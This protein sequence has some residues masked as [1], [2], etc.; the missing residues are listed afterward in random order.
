MND[1]MGSSGENLTKKFL[2]YFD[3]K[4]LYRYQELIKH[5]TVITESN[6]HKKS[7]SPQAYYKVFK[8]YLILRNRIQ[9]LAYLSPRLQTMLDILYGK[10][11]VH[12]SI[13]FKGA[14]SNLNKESIRTYFARV[15]KR[16]EHSLFSI[17]LDGIIITYAKNNNFHPKKIITE[18]EQLHKKKL[19][20]LSQKYK[21]QTRIDLIRSD[22]KKKLRKL[23]KEVDLF[24]IFLNNLY[25]KSSEFKLGVCI[26]ICDGITRLHGKSISEYDSIMKRYQSMYLGV[27]I[28]LNALFI[29]ITYVGSLIPIEVYTHLGKISSPVGLDDL[30]DTLGDIRGKLLKGTQLE[31]QATALQKLVGFFKAKTSAAIISAPPTL[32]LPDMPANSIVEYIKAKL[33][34]RTIRSDIVL[35]ILL[36]RALGS[37]K[38]IV[39]TNN[40]KSAFIQKIEKNQE[41]NITPLSQNDLN[42]IIQHAHEIHRLKKSE[43]KKLLEIKI[44]G[45][46]KSYNKDVGLKS[47]LVVEMSLDTWGVKHI[48]ETARFI[49]PRRIK[50]QI[51]AANLRIITDSGNASATDRAMGYEASTPTD[52][53]Y[54]AA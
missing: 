14:I 20:T 42:A 34:K 17:L 49:N 13:D 23:S 32:D 3:A 15:K 22:V 18:I 10:N 24:Y 4:K 6:L 35:S 2:Q 12:Y 26:E 31:K 47:Y 33:D 29:M 5:L 9:K 54:N 8:E 25:K 45:T 19:T 11:Y 16:K 36:K 39:Y 21:T 50:E 37:P 44:N 38:A 7:I 28:G 46:Q 48:L 40:T 41:T 51:L 43:K 52:I 27:T 53:S 1:L 30:S